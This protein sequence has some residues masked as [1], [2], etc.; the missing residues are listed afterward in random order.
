M[1]LFYTAQLVPERS[2]GAKRHVKLNH[3]SQEYPQTA[4]VR[5]SRLFV[6]KVVLICTVRLTNSLR[7]CANLTVQIRTTLVTNRRDLTADF[8]HTTEKCVTDLLT[9]FERCKVSQEVSTELQPH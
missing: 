5:K 2:E 4:K 3:L 8:S 6:T 7:S 9:H 1:V